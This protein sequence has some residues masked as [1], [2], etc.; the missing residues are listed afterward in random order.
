MPAEFPVFVNARTVVVPVGAAVREAIR[1]AEPALLPVC[2]VG[3]AALTDGRGLPVALDDRLVA[4]AILRVARTSRRGPS[5]PADD[6][7]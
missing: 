1:L 4:G 3:E 5:V 6:G 2:E 7:G